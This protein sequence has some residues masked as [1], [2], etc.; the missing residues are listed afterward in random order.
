MSAWEYDRV[1]HAQNAWHQARR[2]LPPLKEDEKKKQPPPLRT[3][4]SGPQFA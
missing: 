1:V 4:G 2:D 3:D